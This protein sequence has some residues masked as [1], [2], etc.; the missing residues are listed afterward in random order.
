VERGFSP[1][2]AVAGV[3]ANN[4]RMIVIIVLFMI[5]FFLSLLV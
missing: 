4:E 2:V 1:A 5:V 3:S